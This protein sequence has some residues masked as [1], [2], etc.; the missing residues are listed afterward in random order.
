M[1]YSET[2]LFNQFGTS[3]FGGPP[4]EQA[5]PEFL[6][7]SSSDLVYNF[8]FHA[9][10]LSFDLS[11]SANYTNN[12]ETVLDPLFFPSIDL[13]TWDHSAGTDDNIASSSGDFKSLC[14]RTL[15]T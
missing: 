7:G 4:S 3:T 2:D 9:D 8:P 6:Q 11:D 10:G 13:S 5:L 1:A 15:S 12:G 14:W